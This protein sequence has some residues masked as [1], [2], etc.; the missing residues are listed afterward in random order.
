MHDGLML[1][2]KKLVKGVL[3]ALFLA[4]SAK[5]H[6]LNDVYV[7]HFVLDGARYDILNEAVQKGELPFIQKTFFENGT[8]FENA[9]TAF[10]TVSTPGYIAFATGLSTGNSGIFFLEWFDRTKR[11]VVGYLTLK[12]YNRV[13]TDLINRMALLDP[14]VKTLYP[15][16]TLFEKLKPHPTAAVYTHFRQGASIATPAAIPAAAIWNSAI[17]KNGLA[18][19]RLSMQSLEKIF[20]KSPETL[21]RYSLVAL[22]GPDFYG[23]KT[24]ATAE[25][26]ALDLKQFDYLLKKFTHRLEKRGLLDQTY[27]IVSSDHGMHDAGK[28]FK[29]RRIIWN[30]VESKKIAYVGN[31]GVSSTF[32]YLPGEKGWEDVPTLARLRHFPGKHRMVDMIELIRNQEAVEWLA[33]RDGVDRVRI[34][35]K[36]GE[37]LITRIPNGDNPLFSYTFSGK[38]PFEYNK[39]FKLAD[40]KSWLAATIHEKHPNA[41]VDLGNLF[42]D[43]MVG[44][45]LVTLED[46]WG[47]R[48]IKA[49][50]HGSLSQSDMH[51][52]LMMAGPGVSKGTRTLAKGVDVFPTVLEWLGL[53]KEEAQNQEG[54]SL[55]SK[56]SGSRDLSHYEKVERHLATIQ[57][58]KDFK[59]QIQ[60]PE[61]PLKVPKKLKKYM[62]W[63]LEQEIQNESVRLA[64][65]RRH[66]D[67]SRDPE[68]TGFRLEPAPYPDT[69]PE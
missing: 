2:V 43:P 67:E 21:P 61:N 4:F 56:Q 59:S 24:G 22:Y 28:L 45:I 7:I 5:A 29:L 36:K 16:T 50:T 9:L 64:R 62:G 20:L 42:A 63:Y 10:P 15:P 3:A 66:P 39:K 14:N 18:L 35:N 27:F 53:P 33:V 26:I 13:N 41:I 32:L 52:P 55:F 54:L 46:P 58:L 51:I 31:R 34:Y 47:F 17:T 8:V 49:G 11:K 57:K 23:H 12:S 60:T 37:G 6:A 48:R 65:L 68:T 19:D 25:D 30:A 44:D 1:P 38:D 69:G 40:A